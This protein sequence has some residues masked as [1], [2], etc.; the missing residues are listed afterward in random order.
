MDQVL[1]DFFRALRAAGV[2]VSIPE[3]LDAA[4]T[5][6]LVGYGDREDFK[7]LRGRVRT[8]EVGWGKL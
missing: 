4:K 3:A 2:K 1:R 8:L 5:V 7:G 6:G